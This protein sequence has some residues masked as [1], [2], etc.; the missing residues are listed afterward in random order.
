CGSPETAR[1]PPT[2][3]IISRDST[4]RCCCCPGHR[5]EQSDRP[6]HDRADRPFRPGGDRRLRG[7][8]PARIPARPS[9]LRAR[10]AIGG[11]GRYQYRRRPQRPCLARRLDRRGDRLWHQ[12]G[13]RALGGAF[14]TSWLTLFRDD[15]GMIAAGSA[16]LRA[17]GP[18]YGFFGLGLALYFSSQGA[19]RLLWPLCAGIL[20]LVI[21]ITGAWLMLRSTADLGDMFIAL[22]LGLAAYGLVNAAAVK[23]G[24]WFAGPK[25]LRI[26]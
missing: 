19:G 18:F 13:D 2:L 11:V 24:A 10:R 16:Y 14:P 12:R 21:G 7:R 9:R 23:A 3:A 25:P 20:R 6:R 8:D 5:A 22:G 15:P 1:N 4:G 26:N 17:V